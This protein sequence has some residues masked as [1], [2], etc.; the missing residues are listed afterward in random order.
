L[1]VHSVFFDQLPNEKITHQGTTN[2]CGA[3]F[4]H[5]QATLSAL[6]ELIERDALMLHWFSGLAPQRIRVSELATP[7]AEDMRIAEKDYGLEIF[8]LDTTQ[9]A[10]VNS[11][12]CVIVDPVLHM[13]AMGGKASHGEDIF[14]KAYAEAISVLAGNRV[15]LEEGKLSTDFFAPND[16]TTT[17][18]DQEQRETQCCTPE[19]VEWVRRHFLSGPVVSAEAYVSRR[20]KFPSLKEE[21]RY[22]LS[23][24]KR[25]SAIHG[26]A[27]NLHLYTYDSRWIRECSF[28]VVRAFVPAF[29]KLHLREQYATPFSKR[30]RMFM[31]ARGVSYTYEHINKVPHFFP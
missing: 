17:L 31:E 4:S 28:H 5:E 15:R 27:Y 26:P 7:F 10:G 9:D 14:E 12:L 29:L 6:Y 8:F 24:F 18:I 1:P 11:C 22:M 30:L 16:F 21:Y 25:L 20:Q 13:V 23:Q 19:A 2:G 3:G